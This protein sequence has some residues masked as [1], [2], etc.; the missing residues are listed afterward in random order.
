MPSPVLGGESVDSGA[1]SDKSRRGCWKLRKSRVA[2]CRGGGLYF[3]YSCGEMLAFTLT[4]FLELMDHG[5]VSWDTVPISF[6]KQVL[7]AG[8]REGMSL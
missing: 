6:I 5:L 1:M 7:S 4:A 2:A 8:E 3:P